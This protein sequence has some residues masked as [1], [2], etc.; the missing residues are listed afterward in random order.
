MTACDSTVAV[1]APPT[2]Q[3]SPA[4]KRMSSRTLTPEESRMDK[5]GMRLSPIPRSVAV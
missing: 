2:P 1:A 5:K 3:R 4:T